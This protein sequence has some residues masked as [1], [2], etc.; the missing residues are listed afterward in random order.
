MIQS[1]VYNAHLTRLTEELKTLED[2]PEE[3]PEAT[4]RALWYAASGEP[5]SVVAA[6]AGELPE[7][8]GEKQNSLEEFIDERL[9]GIPLAHL[10]KRQQFMGVELLAGPQALV[11]RKETEILGTAALNLLKQICEG[12]SSVMVIDVCTGAGN[13]ATAF[14]VHVPA[15]KIFAA[16]LSKDAVELARENVNFASVQDRVE[17][18]DGDLLEPY[19]SDEFLGKV[20]LLTCNPPYISSAKVEVMDKEISDFEPSLAF[21]GGPFGIKI[22]QKLM[23]EAPRY[24]KHDG[25]LAFEIGLGQ[26]A[27]IMKRLDKNKNFSN[28]QSF[29][30]EAGEIRAIIAQHKTN[31]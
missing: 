27:P 3:N 7:L 23:Q 22:I 5:R 31:A 2:K 12:Q 24:L 1:A 25:W 10:T 28:L 29:N 16:D 4:L 13:L 30:D 6:G 15:A 18:R 11:P 21:D 9:Q 14:A 26:G 17:V 8:S 19:D 20:D